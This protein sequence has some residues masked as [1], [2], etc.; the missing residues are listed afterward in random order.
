MKSNMNF[1]RIIILTF[2]LISTF[3]NTYGNE[4]FTF[5]VTEIEI[6]E[7]GDKF[8]GKKGGKAITKNGITIY[9][10]NFEYNKLKNILYANTKVKIEDK[11]KNI[12]IF[13]DKITYLKNDEIVFTQNKS[14]LVKENVIINAKSFVFNRNENS[15]VADGNV[16]IDDKINNYFAEVEKITYLINEEK[17]ITHGETNAKVNSKYNFYGRNVTILRNKKEFFS[18]D[19]S[20]IVD[21]NFTQYE[22]DEYVYF[23]KKQF[24][25]AKNIRV[26]SNNSLPE[27]ETDITEFKDGFFDLKNKN[28]KASNTTVKIKKNS[29]DNSKNDPR[30]K[31]ISSESKNGITKINKAIFTSCEITEDNCPPWSIKARTI[32]HD[33]NKK[34][35]LYDKAILQIY[36]KPV[37]YFPKF[38]HPDPS[39]ERQSGFLRP[40][41]NNSEILGSSL[42]MPYFHIISQNKDITLK[43]TIFDKNIQM[44]QAEYRQENLNSSFIADFNLVKG[45]E[46]AT[47]NKKSS[48]THL[49]SKYDLDLKIK[50]YTNS[51]VS[52]FVEKLN[53]DTY[54]KVFDTNLFN[55]DK[56]IKPKNN[57][58]LHSGVKLELDND[59]FNFSAGMD[60]FEDLAIGKSSDKYE[61][62]LP[63]F[64]FSKSLISNQLGIIDFSSSGSNKLSNT[65]NLRSR[66][67]NDIKFS[68]YDFYSKQGLKSD[69]N[70]YFKNLNSL[71]KNDVKY[72]NRPSM[73]IASIYEVT[74]SLPLKKINQSSIEYLEPKVSFRINPGDMQDNSSNNRIINT[75]NVFNINRI[76][77]NDTFEAGRSLT[78]GINYKREKQNKD[79]L[80]TSDINNFF[81]FNAA[82]V[83]RN[84]HENFIPSSSTLNNK[85]SNFFGSIKNHYYSTDKSNPFD[86]LKFDYYFSIDDQLENLEYSSLN[87]EI[88]FDKFTTAFNFIEERGSI[89]STNTL[90]NSFKYKFDELNF[91]TFSTRR[92]KKISLTE[93][94]DLLY[95]Y[96]ND[97]L[98]AGIKYKKTYYQDRDLKPTEDLMLTFTFYPLTTYEQ[99][100]DQSLYRN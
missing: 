83:I 2:F 84:S 36:D 9:A 93:Y 13:A 44:Y 51:F 96:K 10:E 75:D 54:L 69:I 19:R 31:G 25:K 22:F 52:F 77:S 100:I 92:N 1:K 89:G 91:I 12:T 15:F 49:F 82:T 33:K 64:N 95:E 71:G 42:N 78:L 74:S 14:R 27:G 17:I 88:S 90:E 86:S 63:Y 53:N 11:F 6:K 56:D 65:N 68:T 70:I 60:I 55:I 3:S 48:L 66:I 47:L 28:Y 76:G 34:Q 30:I 20:K 57:S 94:Y 37:M 18:N 85:N 39:V 23:F 21:N 97:C 61:Y 43:P 24:L 45:Y 67:I 79:T 99:E 62:I 5:D 38:F 73:E 32:T 59:D 41:L 50:N 16:K 46:S 40:Q 80:T 4:S 58:T 35:L 87:G 81:E 72:K 8:F 26:I 29:F 7:N 98:T